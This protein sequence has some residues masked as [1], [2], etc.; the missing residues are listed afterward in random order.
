LAIA[1]R[2]EIFAKELIP[3]IVEIIMIC[4]KHHYTKNQLIILVSYISSTL[5]KGK[6]YYK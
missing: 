6:N 3:K 1:L 5:P 4:L 2:E